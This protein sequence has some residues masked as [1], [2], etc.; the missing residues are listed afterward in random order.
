MLKKNKKI[1]QGGAKRAGGNRPKFLGIFFSSIKRSLKSFLIIFVIGLQIALIIGYLYFIYRNTIFATEGIRDTLTYQGK[2]TNADG[3]P[4]PDGLYD[5]RFRIYS[6]ATSGNLLWAENWDGTNQGTSGSKVQVNDGIFTVELNSLCGNWVGTCASNGGVTFSTDSFYLQVELDYDANGT[7]EEVFLPRKRFTATPYAMNADKLN[8]KGSADFVQ[9]EGGEMTGNLSVPK[10]IDS[11]LVADYGFN[12]NSDDSSPNGLTGTLE[13]SA[14]AANDV[15][16]LDGLNQYFSVA[17]DDKLSFGN[18]T[19]D[20]A[21]T[22]SAW[23]KMDE[24]TNFIIASK[25]TGSADDEYKFY[26]NADDKINLQLIDQ[27]QTNTYLGRMFNTA[28]TSYE[29]EWANVIATYDSSKTS[30]GIKLYINGIEVDDTVN[31]SNSSSYAG[32]ENLTGA[33]NIGNYAANYARGQFD[34]VKVFNRALSPDEI[35]RIYADDN[36]QNI[37]SNKITT[38]TIYLESSDDEN[39]GEGYL[40]WDNFYQRIKFSAET[41]LPNQMPYLANRANSQDYTHYSDENKKL[42]YDFSD[43]VGSTVTDL[44]GNANGTVNGN[45][46]WTNSGYIGY[47]MKFG[48]DGDSVSFADPGLSSTQ[49]SIEFWVKFNDITASAD[50]YAF[51]LAESTSNEIV[52]AKEN[53]S[54]MYFKVGDTKIPLGSIPDTS[55]HYVVIAWDSGNV[56]FYGDGQ[57]ALSTAY[58]NLDI[59]RF[60]KF[61]LGSAGSPNTSLDGE[62]DSVAIYDDVLTPAEVKNHF[63]SAFENLYVANNLSDGNISS[64]VGSLIGLPASTNEKDKADP[65]YF[66]NDSKAVGL[67]FAEGQGTTTSNITLA[68]DPTITGTTWQKGY[69]GYGLGF[70]G[71]SDY[72]TLTDS[73]NLNM[74]TDNFSLE[75]YLKADSSDQ[76]N[77]RIISKRS[78]DAGY[79]V[80]FDS[81][82]KIGFFIGDGTNTYSTNVAGGYALNDGKWHHVLIA[83]DR[84]SNVTMAY[85]GSLTYIQNITSVTGSLDNA[86]DLYIGKDS[87]GNF[88]KGILDSLVIYKSQLLNLGD[89]I[90][91]ATDNPDKMVINS[92]GGISGLAS[93][94]VLNNYTSG[95]GIIAGLFNSNNNTTYPLKIWNAASSVSG[96]D[97][98]YNLISF[99]NMGSNYGNLIWDATNTQFIFDQSLKTTGDL[100]SNYLKTND[101]EFLASDLI[102]HTITSDDV[103][104]TYFSESW[105]KATK[106]KIASLHGVHYV[107]SGNVYGDQDFWSTNT[108]NRIEYDGSAIRVDKLGGTWTEGDVI[109]IF[110]VY[111]K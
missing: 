80:Y 45:A 96:S 101:N 14:S 109:T 100:A 76:T 46:D 32:M 110:V 94:L 107:V 102:R 49:G 12:G 40:A 31:E 78:G 19:D 22:L 68:D 55:W 7:F 90:A 13:N 66:S 72:L 10:I 88:Y 95:D 8:G 105:A 54:D 99:G 4:P 64:P 6:Q 87:S 97:T 15:L 56:S 44:A 67:A 86:A 50:N 62:I 91:R 37:H 53:Q 84:S 65:V 35:K 1:A 9:I 74:G 70:N 18:G 69:Y 47:G 2:I 5:M 61:Y 51:R 57:F 29:G 26:I 36:R 39:T 16:T 73:A 25:G 111:E 24:A 11:S 33:F 23:I 92:R 108:E 82:N 63:N 27:S 89:I 98:I 30:A 21:F 43:S 103:T 20:S 79:E 106:D 52:F 104:N 41:Y 3:V 58:S 34:E 17:D 28:L 85:D 83:F 42:A 93:L 81:N 71:L 77:K 59:S 38:H 75:F 48:A 60:D